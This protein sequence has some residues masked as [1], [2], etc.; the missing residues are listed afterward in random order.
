MFPCYFLC[1]WS[2]YS[3]PATWCTMQSE[4]NETV[5]SIGAG[6]G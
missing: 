6:M 3:Q 5:E 2:V 4:S 1:N